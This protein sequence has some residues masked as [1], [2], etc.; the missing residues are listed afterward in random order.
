M[1]PDGY[2][3]AGLTLLTLVGSGVMWTVIKL[4]R[5]ETLLKAHLNDGRVHNYGGKIP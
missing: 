2:A 5:V 1:S 4:T 3:T